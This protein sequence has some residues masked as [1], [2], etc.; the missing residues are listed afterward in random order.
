MKTNDIKALHQLSADELNKKIA[1]LSQQ[2][3]VA[4]MNHSVGKLGNVAS[5]KTL[6][7]DIAV[8]KTVLSTLE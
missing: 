8:V 4:R 1:E 7:K 5:L 2:Y 6:R 3:A